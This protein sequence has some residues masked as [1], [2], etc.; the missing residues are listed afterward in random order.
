MNLSFPLQLH[1]VFHHNNVICT[2]NWKSDYSTLLGRCRVPSLTQRRKFCFMYQVVN[3]LIVFPPEFIERCTMSRSLRNQSVFDLQRSTCIT[4]AYQFSFS[5]YHNI[6]EQFAIR[7]TKL[8]K[9]NF[10]KIKE[11]YRQLSYVSQISRQ[12]GIYTCL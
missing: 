10:Y 6:L 8:Y 11:C 3:Q 4:S 1:Q 12:I 2:G 7:S 5:P 9:A